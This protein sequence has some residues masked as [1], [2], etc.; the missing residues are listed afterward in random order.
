MHWC[1]NCF[2]QIP[3]WVKLKLGQ[4]VNRDIIFLHKKKIHRNPLLRFGFMIK[5]VTVA[6]TGNSV[7][8]S[9][10]PI[11]VDHFAAPGATK[12]PVAI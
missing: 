6:A 8:H 12:C 10:A 4:Q 11:Y 2:S 5:F 9:V 3:N 7:A 1:F